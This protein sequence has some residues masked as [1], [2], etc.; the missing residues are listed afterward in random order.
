MT[1]TDVAPYRV[2]IH[3]QIDRSIDACL[4]VV[5]L[6]NRNNECLRILR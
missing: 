2:M 4:S 5:E 3:R 6:Q 1:M